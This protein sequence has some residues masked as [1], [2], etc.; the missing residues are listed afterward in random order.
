MPMSASQNHWQKKFA[1]SLLRAIKRHIGF[2]V[3]INSIITML[4]MV[5]CVLITSIDFFRQKV[6]M[7]KDMSILRL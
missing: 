2:S 1:L 6:L 3:K 7:L 5:F 4:H